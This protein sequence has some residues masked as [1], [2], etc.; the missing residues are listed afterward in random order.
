[1]EVTQAAQTEV[2]QNQATATGASSGT[3]GSTTVVATG[4]VP[5]SAPVAAPKGYR[6]KLQLMLQGWQGAIPSDSTIVSSAGNLTQ[7][8]VVAQLQQYLGAFT[9]LDT[10]DTAYKQAR[11]SVEQQSSEAEQYFA[12]LKTALGNAFGPASPQLEQFGLKPKKARTPLTSTQLAIR[13][14][15]SLA[16]RKLRGTRGSVQKA[17]LKSGPMQVS[18]G[19]V[20]TGTA[21]TASTVSPVGAA[22][23]PSK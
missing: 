3:A 11:V 14:A 23:P 21:S 20:V 10:A 17:D 7:A 1:M 8:A 18:V 16:T 12:L 4:T 22:D 2:G 15:K 13:A 19:P 6:L 5:A 9:A